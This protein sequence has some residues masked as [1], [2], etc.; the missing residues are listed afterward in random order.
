MNLVYSNK[1]NTVVYNVHATKTDKNRG[2]FI[3]SVYILVTLPYQSAPTPTPS[4]T[5]VAAQ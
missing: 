2:I 4:I 1:D 5:C 3:T